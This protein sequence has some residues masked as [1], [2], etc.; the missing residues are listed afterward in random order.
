[1]TWFFFDIFDSIEAQVINRIVIDV[2]LALDEISTD[3][4][5]KS[6]TEKFIELAKGNLG[7]EPE[8]SSLKASPLVWF[9]EYKIRWKG[10]T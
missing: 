3:Q 1:M 7:G 9:E 4:G 2:K 8:S 5:T 10:P 6:P